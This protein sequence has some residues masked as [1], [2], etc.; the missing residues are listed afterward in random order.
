MPDIWPTLL[1]WPT[2]PH[3]GVKQKFTRSLLPSNSE[4]DE[5]PKIRVPLLHEPCSDSDG[6]KFVS[7]PRAPSA[8]QF[9][10]RSCSMRSSSLHTSASANPDPSFQGSDRIPRGCVKPTLPCLERFAA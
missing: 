2:W 8:R 9:R 3:F 6:K 5:S 1:L 4:R 7:H 10:G